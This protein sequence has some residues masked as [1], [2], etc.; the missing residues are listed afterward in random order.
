MRR[1]DRS[2][3]VEDLSSTCCLPRE[4]SV[5]PLAHHRGARRVGSASSA[6]A[7]SPRSSRIRARAS[8]R[9]RSSLTAPRSPRAGRRR[10][11][12]SRAATSIRYQIGLRTEE[13]EPGGAETTVEV[14]QL[15]QPAVDTPA[16]R[17]AVPDQPGGRRARSSARP[18]ACCSTASRPSGGTSRRSD[19]RRLRCTFAMSSWC[20]ATAPGR[21]G[22][23][24][25]DEAYRGGPGR[26]RGDA[27]VLAVEAM[28]V[29]ILGA[30]GVVGREMLRTLERR[31]FPVDELVPLASPRSAGVKLPFAGERGDG[32]SR[33][34]RGVRGRGR[35][36][37]LAGR[38]GLSPSGRRK[39]SRPA[40]WSSTTPPRSGWTP[41]CPSSSPRS[42]ATTSATQ[43]DRRQP[44]LHRDHRPDGGRAAPPAGGPGTPDRLLVSV[45]LG[46]GTRR[47]ST[48]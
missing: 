22:S 45:R 24:S 46:H 11:A 10:H 23:S 6:G 1:L 28:K 26:V 42:T 17:A 36:P 9:A 25:T 15:D 27:R 31:S 18:R 44:E 7:C 43:G 21:S 14:A 30:S 37:V 4:T 3:E 20:A 12:S 33:R 2:E 32:S 48:S 47:G 39:R 34:R 8:T 41:T 40:P 16:V 35:R 19:I 5:W 29:A 38:D 13:T